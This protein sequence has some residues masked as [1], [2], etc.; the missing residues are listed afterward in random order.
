MTRDPALAAKTQ[1][2]GMSTRQLVWRLGQFISCAALT[3]GRSGDAGLSK[4][5]LE[6]AAMVGEALGA[7][8]PPLFPPAADAVQGARAALDYVLRTVPEALATAVDTLGSDHRIVLN[9]SLRLGLLELIAALGPGELQAAEQAVREAARSLGLPESFQQRLSGV[10]ER[11]GMSDAA[12]HI[13]ETYRE[14]YSWLGREPIR[15]P[16]VR[17]DALESTAPAVFLAQGRPKTSALRAADGA[18]DTRLLSWTLGTELATAAISRVSPDRRQRG[19]ELFRELGET[20]AQ[21]SITLPPL[22]AIVGN[23]GHDTSQAIN[24]LVFGEGTTIAEQLERRHGADRGALFEAG[25]KLRVWMILY[26]PNGPEPASHPLATIEP[27]VASLLR[28]RVPSRIWGPLLAMEVARPSL[29]DFDAL[30]HNVRQ[31]VL[32]Y[33]GTRR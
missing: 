5:M 8:P 26:D 19:D 23:Y 32:S 16:Q 33:L 30:C 31:E 24:Y 14:A 17:L 9:C 2:L 21:L 13:T 10:V 27:L 11:I 22:P 6:N 1:Q 15:T 12:K 7:V 28:T 3:H 25:A 29:A 18:A 20:G 4:N